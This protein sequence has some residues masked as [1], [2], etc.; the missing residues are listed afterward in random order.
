MIKKISST[1]TV[2][3]PL[4]D[5]RQTQSCP[6]CGKQFPHVTTSD[7]GVITREILSK[8]QYSTTYSSNFVRPNVYKVQYNTI[9]VNN[10][11][12]Q[13]PSILSNSHD[14]VLNTVELPIHPGVKIPLTIYGENGRVSYMSV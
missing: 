11:R 10:S 6:H 4:A 13:H 12:P 1:E 7:Q 5:S 8:F 3:V 9:S 14:A 2:R